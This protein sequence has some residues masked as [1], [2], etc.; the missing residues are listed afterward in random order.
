M[1]F[2]TVL[3]L[4]CSLAG[5]VAASSYS[6]TGSYDYY[7]PPSTTVVWEDTTTPKASPCAGLF[8]GPCGGKKLYFFYK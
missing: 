5:Y 4:L 1:K 8:N 3:L 2:L 7:N 6:T